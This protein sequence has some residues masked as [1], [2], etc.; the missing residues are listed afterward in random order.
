MYN[1]DTFKPVSPRSAVDAEQEDEA[2][3]RVL[4]KSN[5]ACYGILTC[6]GILIHQEIGA[7]K[8]NPYLEDSNQ[9]F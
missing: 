3:E 5:S 8:A 7:Q 2:V 9:C 1:E 4:R 6:Y